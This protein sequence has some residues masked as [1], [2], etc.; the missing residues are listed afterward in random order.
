MA[1]VNIDRRQFFKY[2]VGGAIA[3]GGVTYSSPSNAFAFTAAAI[4]TGEQIGWM[5]KP[6]I[7]QGRDLL[8]ESMKDL[9][10]STSGAV[11]H[12]ISQSGDMKIKAIEQSWN[13]EWKRKTQPLGNECAYQEISELSIASAADDRS[14]NL[15]LN[16]KTKLRY[17]YAVT[18]ELEVDYNTAIS[19]AF[20]SRGDLKLD[21][22]KRKNLTT[23]Y[24][25]LG[26]IPTTYKLERELGIGW[27]KDAGKLIREQMIAAHLNRHLAGQLS[28][29][30][31]SIKL[32][33]DGTYSST[34]WRDSLN[35]TSADL[36]MAQQLIL[37]QAA[38]NEV[39]FEQLLSE[40]SLLT[41]DC[42]KAL[43][44]LESN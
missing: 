14:I 23:F 35:E 42:M 13:T 26:N 16:D 2:A 29:R 7:D 33:I 1:E 25:H 15:A 19:Y 10:S 41:T 22:S 38:Q 3:G 37:L 31:A 17:K 34:P 36:T 6:L 27:E 28:N 40:Q 20:N 21:S 8:I 43:E 32:K 18:N 30:H 4:A 12:A 24:M 39:L 9:F 11:G 5:A 44:K